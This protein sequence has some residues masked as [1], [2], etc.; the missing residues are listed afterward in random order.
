M[1]PGCIV[2]C[3]EL[4]FF[5]EDS[6]GREFFKILFSKKLEENVLSGQ[7]TSIYVCPP[8]NKMSRLVTLNVD[9]ADRIIIIADADGRDIKYEEQSIKERIK[10]KYRECI[11]I[12]LLDYEIEEWICYSHGI[13]FDGQNPS[14]IL[15]HK[16]QY[17]KK[18]LPKYGAKLDC[19]K[20]MGCESFRR[21]LSAL[22]ST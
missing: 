10:G 4:C 11:R 14:K 6:F 9:N 1:N 2:K 22:E 19:K 13:K 5:V 7:I 17:S 3:Y 21:F 18:R 12:V 15:K 20:L 16:I 8:G